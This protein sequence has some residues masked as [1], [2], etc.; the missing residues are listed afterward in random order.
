MERR[1]KC[2]AEVDMMAGHGAMRSVASNCMAEVLIGM[3]LAAR[4]RKFGSATR[5]ACE[6]DV[7]NESVDQR[8]CDP[9]M[10]KP[11]RLNSPGGEGRDRREAQRPD[12]EEISKRRARE[13][14]TDLTPRMAALSDDTAEQQHEKVAHQ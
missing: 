4:D 6:R 11:G 9:G 8:C 5:K 3:E 2:S 7:H 14:R 12:A 13:S 1:A 10:M